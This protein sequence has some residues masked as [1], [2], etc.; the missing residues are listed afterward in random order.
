MAQLGGGDETVAVLIEDAERLAD[1]LLA[2]G[3]LHFPGHHRQELGEIDCA[4]TCDNCALL[5][6]SILTGPKWKMTC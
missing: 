6:R 4:V 5:G 2:V 1:L 3:V